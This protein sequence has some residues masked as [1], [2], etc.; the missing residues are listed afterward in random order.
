MNEIKASYW[1]REAGWRDRWSDSTTPRTV[2]F[3]IIGGGLSGLTTAIRLRDL[4][5]GADIVLLEAERVGYGA[6]GRNGG[7]LSPLAAPVWLLG[8]ERCPEQAWAATRINDEVH[9]TA[10]W[11]SDHVPDAELRA[12]RF[13]IEATGRLSDCGLSQLAEVVDSIGLVH[14]IA[15]SRAR[16][17]R[18]FLE[19]DAY[20]VQP[21]KLVLALAHRAARAG[22]HICERARVRAVEA[23]PIGARVRLA[24]DAEILARRVIVCT[25]AYTSS[26]DVGERVR[27]VVVHNYMLASAPLDRSVL[28][29][30]MRDGDFTLELNTAQVFHRL[31]DNRILYGGIDTLFAPA[32]GDFDVPERVRSRLGKLFDASFPRTHIAATEAWGGTYHS[33]ATE[34]PIIRPSR[35]NPAVILNV[36]YGGTGVALA[37]AC[38]RLAAGLA[39]GD[40]LASTDDERLLSIIQR[41]KFSV[42]DATR[43]IARLVWNLSR[44]PGRFA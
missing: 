23:A 10:R 8:A 29:R 18:R 31:H 1:Q 35:S 32:G 36:G 12:A 2:D 15:K 11:L 24:T 4:H 5:P 40:K 39:T 13:S 6:S 20:T 42:R 14:R 16:P 38:A 33:T 9:A 37:L 26:V 7:F 22:V 43:A 41:T 3:A 27:A 21:Y 44:R 30:I 34:L 28:A 25:N 19:L 17:G